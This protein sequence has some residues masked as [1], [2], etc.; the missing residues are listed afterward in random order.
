[1]KN[2][3][4]DATTITIPPSVT[5]IEDSAYSLCM[6]LLTITIPPSVTTIKGHAFSNCF[7]LSTITI[8]PLVTTIDVWTFYGCKSLSGVTIPPS[9]TVIKEKAFAC[10]ASLSTIKIP[11][12]ILLIA[13]NTFFECSKLTSIEVDSSLPYIIIQN[14]LKNDG[15]DVTI[16]DKLGKLYD[17]FNQRPFSLISPK[18]YKLLGMGSKKYYA[19]IQDYDDVFVNWKIFSRNRNEHGRLLLFTALEN[20]IKWSDSL[21][22]IVEGYGAAIEETDTVTALEAFML[23]A[24]GTNSNMETVYNLLQYHPAAINPY[25]S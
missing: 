20:S 5:I 13:Y 7:N 9:I 19:E 6:S 17:V 16:N 24:V 10:C 23:A 22:K 11:P 2:I 15:Y 18:T 3:T 12:T 8:P 1:M 21:C 14:S 25:V 4:M